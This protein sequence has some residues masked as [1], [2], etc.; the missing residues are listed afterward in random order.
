M[1]AAIMGAVEWPNSRFPEKEQ[2][3][4]EAATDLMAEVLADTGIEKGEID[5][6]FLPLIP[7]QPMIAPAGVVEYLGLRVNMGEIVD[8]GGATPAAALWRAAMAIEAGVCSTCLLLFPH[9]KPPSRY[10]NDGKIVL[11]LYAGGDVW[12]APQS[13]YEFPS[14][15]VAAIPSFAML[16][17]A[18]LSTYG[19]SEESLAMVA[20]EQ[21]YNA[22]GNDK[23]LFNARPLSLDDVMA[24]PKICD[25][26]KLPEVVMPCFGG[27]A[28]LI[29]TQA[30]AKRGPNR[31]VVLSGYAENIT[32]KSMTYVS[33]LLTTPL[34]AASKRALAMAGLTHRDF[35][36]ASI[37][38]CFTVTVPL[39]LE[40]AGFCKKGQG[41]H[42]L[43][44]R[45]MRFDGGGF[46]VNPHGGQLGSGQAGYAGGA[47]HI[48]DTVFQLQNRA[49]GHQVPNARKAFV[50]GTGGLMSEQIALVL[51]AA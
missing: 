13:L 42:F 50:N 48:N 8:M 27:S 32:H 10:E 43:R 19:L 6:L 20:S 22:Q 30:R 2:F 35:D 28:L 5:G 26:I 1:R 23:A 49:T 7:E 24:A 4:L 51:E 47:A 46:P 18:Y 34:E 31:P 14:G 37:Y 9:A 41:T 16:A 39:T 11:P 45:S 44:E 29:T 36:L 40:N 17:R 3:W 38:D 15:I 33:D 21:R 25:P 12:G